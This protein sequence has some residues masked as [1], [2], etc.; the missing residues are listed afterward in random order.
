MG[1][2]TCFLRVGPVETDFETELHAGVVWLG[3]FGK[4]IEEGE[5]TI[6]QWQPC[7]MLP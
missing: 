3:A 4:E 6:L 7:Q 1:D 5:I 2:S